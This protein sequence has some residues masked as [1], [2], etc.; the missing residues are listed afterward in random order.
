MSA[1]PDFKMLMDNQFKNVKTHAR[2][3]S[4]AMWYEW[5]MKLQDGLKEGL[6]KISQE[7]DEDDKSLKAQRELLDSVLPN[8]L[9]RYETLSKEYSNLE[10]YAKELAECDP[11]ELQ[12][13]RDEL[14]GVENDIE[15]KKKAIAELRSELQE[16]GTEIERISA[17]KQE[18]LED[19][20]ESEKIREECRGWST[21]EIS[22]HKGM[23]R[24][25]HSQPV[26]VTLEHTTNA[27]Q[28]NSPGRS[29]RE[30]TRLVRNR[31]VRHTGIPRLQAGHR[32]RP[33]CRIFP[34]QPAQLTHR[35]VAHRHP[36]RR[37]PAHRDPR[38]GILPTADP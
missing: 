5:R 12:G 10:R 4:K 17:K 27:K 33:R 7:M 3:L 2:L 16:T 36:P 26:Q 15:E 23:T 32:A 20:K 35:R 34:A 13:A 19:I 38:A 14:V 18:S 30:R 21:T 1:T 28:R 37:Q 25:C 22:F 9:S 8:V 31:R 29:P 6:L 24:L 11:E